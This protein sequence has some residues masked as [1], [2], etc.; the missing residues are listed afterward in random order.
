MNNQTCIRHDRVF[1]IGGKCDLCERQPEKHDKYQK[2]IDASKVV[3][4]K[5]RELSGNCN[6]N[7]NCNCNDDAAKR[8]EEEIKRAEVK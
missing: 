8:L 3:L 6:C 2:L 5:F 1:P 4:V 7:C